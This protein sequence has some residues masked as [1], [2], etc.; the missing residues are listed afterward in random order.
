MVRN[1]KGFSLVVL[2]IVIAIMA[3]LVGIVGTQVIPYLNRTREAKDTQA[4]TAFASAGISAYGLNADTTDGL[5]GF[6]IQVSAAG[7][8]KDQY[9]PVGVP[10]VQAIADTMKELISTDYVTNAST[11]FESVSFRHT[12]HIDVIFDFTAKKIYVEAYDSSGNLLNSQNV[13]GVL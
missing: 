9:I 8:G 4:L 11:S 5:T 7:D 3:V 2:I 12:D 10:Q 1:E 6:T 13:M